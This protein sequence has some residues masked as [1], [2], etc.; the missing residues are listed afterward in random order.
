MKTKIAAAKK[1]K[2]KIAAAKVWTGDL[3][4]KNPKDIPLG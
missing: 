3:L 4:V 1:M 2:T